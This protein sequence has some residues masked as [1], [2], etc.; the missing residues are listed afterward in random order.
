MYCKL[1]SRCYNILSKYVKLVTHFY[2]LFWKITWNISSF[3][4]LSAEAV[5]WR[6]YYFTTILHL[7]GWSRSVLV[8][9]VILVG[10]VM[11]NSYRYVFSCYFGGLFCNLFLSLLSLLQHVHSQWLEG[12]W[13][14]SWSYSLWS[15]IFL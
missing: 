5:K 11:I 1:V 13:L 4:S 3:I 12:S 7:Q 9:F 6:I 2:I 8:L 15:S 14:C 10:M